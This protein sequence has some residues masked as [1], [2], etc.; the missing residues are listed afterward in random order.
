MLDHRTIAQLHLALVFRL[1]GRVL[2]LAGGSVDLDA[3]PKLRAADIG[4]VAAVNN[5][6]SAGFYG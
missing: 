1:G 4:Q 2:V 6:V 5:E 3:T